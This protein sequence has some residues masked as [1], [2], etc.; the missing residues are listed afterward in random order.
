LLDSRRLLLL[1]LLLPQADIMDAP[2][3][4]AHITVLMYHEQAPMRQAAATCLG[5]LTEHRTRLGT[6]QVCALHIAVCL[7]KANQ[8]TGHLATIDG[9]KRALLTGH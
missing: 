2:N 5:N 8:L 4:L 9:L 6:T 3:A 1:L 7:S